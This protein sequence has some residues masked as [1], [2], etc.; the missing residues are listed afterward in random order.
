MNSIPSA[1]SLLRAVSTSSTRN[2][3]TGPVE[4]GAGTHPIRREGIILASSEYRAESQPLVRT[5]AW[6][7]LG[8]GLWEC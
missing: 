7:A 4:M 2:P 8:P 5:A 1:S 3:R 6:S